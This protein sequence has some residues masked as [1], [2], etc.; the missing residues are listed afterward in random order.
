PVAVAANRPPSSPST[1]ERSSRSIAHRRYRERHLPSSNEPAHPHHQPLGW[2]AIWRHPCTPS[3]T[4]ATPARVCSGTMASGEPV[5]GEPMGHSQ[6]RQPAEVNTLVK[7]GS[8][9]L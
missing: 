3:V 8:A 2:P 4:P 5:A 1:E 6:V 9:L 7:Q